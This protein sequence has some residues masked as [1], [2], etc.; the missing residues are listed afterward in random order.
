MA[1]LV[2]GVAQCAL[3][4]G[5][6]KCGA[7][8]TANPVLA[9]A[10]RNAHVVGRRC[11]VFDAR[12]VT[13]R[14]TPGRSVVTVAAATAV[15]DV[16][17]FDGEADELIEVVVHESA[18]GTRSLPAIV[19]EKLELQGDVYY[20]CAPRD[21]PVVLVREDVADD[22]DETYFVVVDDGPELQK[23]LPEAHRVMMERANL[24]LADTA[25]VLTLA[26]VRNEP[27]LDTDWDE[28]MD[29]AQDDSS[30]ASS[31]IDAGNEDEDADDGADEDGHVHDEFCNHEDDGEAEMAEILEEFEFGPDRE[32]YLICRSSDNVIVIAKESLAHPGD[33]EIPGPEELERVQPEI[34]KLLEEKPA[35]A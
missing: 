29:D 35:F 7:K 6:S 23:L 24:T 10:A 28:D 33:L 2:A 20:I 5:V 19:M 32:K 14:S 13:P 26:G 8:Q 34:E 12:A 30:G 1:F 31:F 27:S 4:G 21:Q 9:A 3:A 18:P 15:D 16:E 22:E 17:S 11:V 25:A